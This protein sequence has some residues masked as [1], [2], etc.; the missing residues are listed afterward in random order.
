M[1]PEGRS[2][3]HDSRLRTCTSLESNG[4]ARFIVR[5]GNCLL[6]QRPQTKEDGLPR[7]HSERLQQK[8]DFSRWLKSPSVFLV[9]KDALSGTLFV[10]F[11]FDLLQKPPHSRPIEALPGGLERFPRDLVTLFR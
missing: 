10:R 5:S 6:W 8:G 3:R 2:A 9:S 11:F 4:F 7:G 1:Q